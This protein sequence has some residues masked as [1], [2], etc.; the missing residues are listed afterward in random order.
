MDAEDPLLRLAHEL[1]R[2]AAA[3]LALG[4]ATERLQAPS[5]S[6]RV[7]LRQAAG[8]SRRAA[9]ATAEVSARVSALAGAPPA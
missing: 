6:D 9:R 5:G 4:E 2:L 8:E 1:E 3:Q 7:E